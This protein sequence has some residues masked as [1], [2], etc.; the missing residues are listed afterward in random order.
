MKKAFFIILSFLVITLVA[1]FYV[2]TDKNIELKTEDNPVIIPQSENKPENYLQITFLDVGQGDAGFIEWPNGEQMLVDCGKDSKVLS[3]L[4]S[5]MSFYDKH[6]DYLLVTHPDMDHYGGCIDVLKRFEVGQIIYNG[7]QG[8]SEAWKYFWDLVL[9]NNI[10]NKKISAF[11]V[12]EIDGSQIKFLYPDKE[13]F[14]KNDNDKSI[15]FVLSYGESDILFTGDAEEELEKY[16][17]EN[18]EEYLDVEILKVAHHG[19]NGSSSED[20]LNKVSPEYSVISVGKD[21]Y[22]RHPSLRAVKR[23]ERIGSGVF[24][25]DMEGDIAFKIYQNGVERLFE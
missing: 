4:G 1:L 10:E 3:G 23:I 7:V 16:L 19:S 21:N 22:Y 8:D 11:D 20:F 5:V 2:K 9:E 6:I 13:V 17:L 12:W 24:R 25:T 14:G 15:V 18:Y